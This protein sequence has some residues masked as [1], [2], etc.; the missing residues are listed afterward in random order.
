MKN[1]VLTEL[2]TQ[3]EEFVAG[4]Q[5]ESFRLK[6]TGARSIT[7][8]GY[9]LCSSMSYVVGPPLW[10][11]LNIYQTD[12]QG[13][14]IGIKMFTKNEDEGDI[15]RVLEASSLDDVAHILENYDPAFDIDASSVRV[16]DDTISMAE[17]SLAA[18]RLRQRIE[19]ARRQF[20]DLVGEIL[21]ELDNG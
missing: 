2:Q 21:Y 14:L 4:P 10:Y 18:V 9:E 3:A 12:S 5:V 13:F 6:Q 16:D 7:F 11:E 8:D 19:E 20:K 17:L 1:A 15:H